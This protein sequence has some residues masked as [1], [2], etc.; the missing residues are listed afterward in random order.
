M[1][2]ETPLDSPPAAEESDVSTWLSDD[3]PVATQST[4]PRTLAD[5]LDEDDDTGPHAV[6]PDSA[7]WESAVDEVL[8]P[9]EAAAAEAE[10]LR[11]LQA[12]QAGAAGAMGAAAEIGSG[13]TAPPG[14]SSTANRPQGNALVLRS[15]NTNSGAGSAG[16]SDAA[17]RA[18][19]RKLLPLAL[20]GAMF[21]AGAAAGVFLAAKEVVVAPPPSALRLPAWL[22]RSVAVADSKLLTAGAAA[23]ATV[24]TTPALFQA[25][26]CGTLVMFT[27][28][29]LEPTLRWMY[30]IWQLADP[31]KRKPWERSIWSWALLDVYRPA[32]AALVVTAAVHLLDWALLPPRTTAAVHATIA[33]VGSAA[34][35][36]AVVTAST[37]VLR[38]WSTRFFAELLF[39]A[40]MS[41]RPGAIS[42]VEGTARLAGIVTTVV[43]A[44]LGAQ[45]LGFDLGSLLAVG[46]ISGLAIG[47]AGREILGNVFAGLMLYATSPFAP[48][49][50]VKFVAGSQRDLIDGNIVDVGLF[51]TTIR[52]FERE[53]FTVPNSLFST[54]V[55]LNV[56]RKGREWRVEELVLVRHGPPDAVQKA[57]KDLRSVIKADERV[58]KNLHR[59]VFL[60]RLTPDGFELIVSFYIEAVNRDQYLAVRE[61]MYLTMLQIFTRYGIQLAT[62]VRAIRVES[63]RASAA[64]PTR[65]E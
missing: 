20:L 62:P 45:A 52:S 49:E 1:V 19:L 32:E 21:V 15:Q 27:R 46:G 39:Q 13:S 42:R 28:Q 65:A 34:V 29:G 33:K 11:K 60:N 2:D 61:D 50:H 23:L 26:L 7:Y 5:L 43:A 48:G 25:A 3:E 35:S 40:E 36:L 57:I 12:R 41:G 56:S 6:F 18:A 63:T 44:L 38:A 47:L 58:L 14:G 53:L 30:D 8:S 17:R 55:V 37:R 24:V 4:P 51:R 64:L 59:R 31:A 9:A 54:T 16:G 10:R 22:A